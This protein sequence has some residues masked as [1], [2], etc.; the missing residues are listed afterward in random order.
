MEQEMDLPDTF[1]ALRGLAGLNEIQNVSLDVA[2]LRYIF[3]DDTDV[4]VTREFAN[5]L[6]FDL[7]L[8]ASHAIAPATIVSHLTEIEAIE[9]IV[10]MAK[11]ATDKMAAV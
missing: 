5:K 10:L 8:P 4:T 3:S 7:W 11:L 1:R 2:A 6:Y 9:Q